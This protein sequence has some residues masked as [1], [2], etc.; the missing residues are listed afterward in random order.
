MTEQEIRAATDGIIYLTGCAVNKTVPD[1]QRIAAMDLDQVYELAHVHKLTAAVGMALESAGLRDE[2]FVKAVAQAQR[3]TALMD[4]DRAALLERMEAAGIWYMPLKGVPLKELYPRYGMREMVDN[5]ILFD[6]QRRR[7]VRDIME[8]LGFQTKRY[9]Q[10]ND[11]DYIKPPVSNFEM[12]IDL[13]DNITQGE[14]HAYYENVKDRLLKDPNS[15][16]GYHFS[17]EDFYLYMVAH[18]FKH[19]S[20]L[21]GTGFRSLLDT[22]VFLSRKAL[23]MD[24]VRREAEKLGIGAFEARNRTLAMRLFAGEAL[25]DEERAVLDYMASSGAFGSLQN[26][27]EN[28]IREKGWDGFVHSRL[29]PPYELM[30]EKYPILKKA[31]VLYPFVWVYRLVSKLFTNNRK[32][33]AEAKVA[34][35]LR[36]VKSEEDRARDKE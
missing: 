29:T 28:Q 2:R 20:G 30:R 35:N 3:R 12:H 19:Y 33:V 6:A 9:G 1:G 10:F 25:S 11:D 14:L 17:D 8:S 4:A 21:G 31:P 27:V 16:Y 15:A 24:Y 18:E 23:D 13:F 36:G 34:L 7:D 26:N 22:Y 5:D 32:I